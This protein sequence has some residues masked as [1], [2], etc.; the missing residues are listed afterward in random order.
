MKPLSTFGLLHRFR[1][2]QLDEYPEVSTEG[3]T[4]RG[5]IAFLR[6]HFI[7]LSLV[8]PVSSVPARGDHELGILCSNESSALVDSNGTSGVGAK[9]RE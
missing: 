7:D 3:E 1:G 8:R 5:L 2:V 4:T 6:E 9:G